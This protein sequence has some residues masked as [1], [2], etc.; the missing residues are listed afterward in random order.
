MEKAYF[1]LWYRLD[2]QNRYLIWFSSDGSQG[3]G[4][5]LRENG[6]IPVFARTAGLMNYAAA[7]G[8]KSMEFSQPHLHNL[9]IVG[10]WL[11]LKPKNRARGVDC[12]EFLGAWNLF[13]AAS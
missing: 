4:V 7:S 11:K 5:V 2:N 9:D 10:R 8:F 6:V 12:I 3:D 1:P 13:A